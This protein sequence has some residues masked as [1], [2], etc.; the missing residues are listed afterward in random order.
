MP[1]NVEIYFGI[2]LSNRGTLD[3]DATNWSI[4]TT[5]GASNSTP[6]AEFAACHLAHKKA[7]LPSLDLYDR[8]LP[9]GYHKVVHE[10]NQ[11]MIQ[12]AGPYRH[13]QDNAMAVKKSWTGDSTSIRPLR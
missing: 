12:M 5:N 13:Q 8:L 7:F 2:S 9:K 1:K 6:E 3:I 11:A 4:S 10:D